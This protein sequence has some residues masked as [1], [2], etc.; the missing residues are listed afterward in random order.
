MSKKVIVILAIAIAAVLLFSG[1]LRSAAPSILATPT[2]KSSINI[3]TPN[4]QT[5]PTPTSMNLLQTWGTTTAAYVQTAVAAGTFTAVPATP[6]ATQAAPT[7][8]PILP[9]T[10]VAT[11]TTAPG[12]ATSTPMPGTTPVVVVPT[13]TPG[14]PA[15]YTLHDGEFPYCLARRFNVDQN[16]IMS[17]NGFVDGQLYKPGQVVLIPQTGSYVGTRAL[18]THPASYTTKVNDTFYSIACYFGDVEPTAIAAA[19]GLAI[20]SPLAT[21][22]ILSIP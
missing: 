3:A 15:N 8:T 4:A 13:S 17:L 16:A 11:N 22:K 20:T 7:V 1:C 12:A 14:R 5:N 19:N 2:A 10:G 6:L 9:A 18:H 21:G